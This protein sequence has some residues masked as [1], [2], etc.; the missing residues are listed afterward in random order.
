MEMIDK[1]NSNNLLICL[2]L[3]SF[4]FFGS[5]SHI[6][7]LALILSNFIIYIQTYKKRSTQE[8]AIPLFFAL[9]GCFFLFLIGGIFRNHSE[10]LM[11]SLS[12]MFPIPLIGLLI[13]FQGSTGFKLSSKQVANFSQISVVFSLLVYLL[14]STS[15]DPESYFYRFHTGRLYLFSGN[16]IP[17]SF[18][19]LGVSLFCLVDWRNSES[20]GK[21]IAVCCFFIGIYFSV[22]LSSTRGALLSLL[23][24][25]PIIIFYLS[26]KFLLTLTITLGVALI[27]ILIFYLSLLGFIEHRYLDNIKNGLQTLTLMNESEGSVLHRLIMW[28]AAIEAISDAPLIGHGITQRFSALKP[29]LQNSVPSHSHPHND[30]FA[31]IIS[32]GIFGAIAAFISLIS[33]FIA[34]LLSPIWSSEK[35][36]FGIMISSLTL[37]TASVST[38]FFNDITS[39]WLAFSTYLV[40]VTNFKENDVV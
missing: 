34:S 28:S 40:W 15:S 16:P 39:A 37:V 22:F 24:I 11:T 30:I 12:P 4:G 17:F 36:Y 33:G 19:L 21:I 18:S 20:K 35:L 1:Q 29:Y 25:T 27:G 14:L 3:V 7:I 5:L 26:N 6:F 31:S 10:N 32:T 38:V 8:Y 13:I 9:T 23:I 2:T